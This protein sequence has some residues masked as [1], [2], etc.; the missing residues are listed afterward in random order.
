M[1]FMQ[2]SAP[3]IWIVESPLSEQ[4]EQETPIQIRYQDL[5]ADIPVGL[6][7]DPIQQRMYLILLIVTMGIGIFALFVL[8][9]AFT[10]NAEESVTDNNNVLPEA[11]TNI[12]AGAAGAATTGAIS[13]VFSQEVQYWASKIV[14][15]SAIYELDPNM[16]ATIMQIES[17]GDPKAISSAGAQ[18]LFQVMPFHFSTGDDMLHPETNAMKGL[19]Y[20]SER[21]QQT[22]GE[23]GHAFAG[24]NGGHV[25][26]GSS[27][28]YWAAE[29][30]RYYT[31]STGIYEEAAAGMTQSETLQE[32]MAA[33]G[34]SLCQQ[35]ANRLGLQ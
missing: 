14:T 21:L 15:W 25:A 6:P 30:Q 12:G 32:W 13:P 31:W 18:G 17:C 28:N 9:K 24:Y 26:A 10:I 3:I 22:S 20:F 5:P 19:A 16:V 35:A 2:Q 1:T 7:K 34:A 4:Y 29:T 27:W 8:P 33:G 23:V 11:V